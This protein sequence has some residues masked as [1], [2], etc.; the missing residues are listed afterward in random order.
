MSCLENYPEDRYMQEEQLG[1][2]SYGCVHKVYDRILDKYVAI[3]SIK[4]NKNHRQ[5]ETL[6][7][8]LLR[9]I[10]ILRNLRD[11]NHS[12]IVRL[13]HV[14]RQRSEK[15]IYL[16]FENMDGGDLKK[17]IEERGYGGLPIESVI[18]FTE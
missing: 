4:Q 7:H 18:D 13:E 2:G 10:D 9:E 17:F 16:V 12:H 14:Y 3:K 5:L 6:P 15:Q 11:F 1:E 8:F